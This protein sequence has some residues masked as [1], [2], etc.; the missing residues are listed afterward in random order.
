MH[1]R[2]QGDSMCRYI[3]MCEIGWAKGSKKGVGLPL[4]RRNGWMHQ[5]TVRG[6]SMAAYCVV[7]DKRGEL[8]ITASDDRLVKVRFFNVSLVFVCVI[9]Q[10]VAF[11][12]LTV[13]KL[14]LSL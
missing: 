8:I 12:A 7:F 4:S 11:Q 9:A 6:H 1:N 5:Y 14:F 10:S 3:A 13:F 2:M